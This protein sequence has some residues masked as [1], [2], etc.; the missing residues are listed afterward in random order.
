MKI[1]QYLSL[2]FIHPFVCLFIYGVNVIDWCEIEHS[3][4]THV[5]LVCVSGVVLNFDFVIYFNLLPCVTINWGRQAHTHGERN[6]END[7]SIRW[8]LPGEFAINYN[9]RYRIQINTHAHQFISR[10]EFSSQWLSIGWTVDFSKFIDKI[11]WPLCGGFS[12]LPF[13][14]IGPVYLIRVY[15]FSQ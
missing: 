7:Y 4:N 5:C 9:K 3:S 15:L 6:K 13:K 11:V 2:L 12:H 1:K 14:I 10:W 8:S